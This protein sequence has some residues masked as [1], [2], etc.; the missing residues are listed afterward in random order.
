MRSL[1][2]SS[3]VVLIAAL[4][5]A[6]A[7]PPPCANCLNAKVWP[8]DPND[9]TQIGDPQFPETARLASM[10]DRVDLGIAF[11]G[12][13][14]R[15]ATATLGQLRGLKHIGWLKR[16]RY[17]AAV[18]GGSWAALPYTYWK[19]ADDDLLGLYQEPGDLDHDKVLNTP[20]GTL[21]KIITE[22]AIAG[23][24]LREAV[25]EFRAFALSEEANSFID[26]FLSAL[27]KGRREAGR[28]NKTYSRLLEDNFIKPLF[29]SQSALRVGWEERSVDQI[30]ADNPGALSSHEFLKVPD[31]RPFFIAGATLVP[32]HPAFYYP[33]LAPVEYTPLYSGIRQQF[34]AIGGAYVAT[35][36]Y[37]SV[38]VSQGDGGLVRVRPAADGRTFTV[39]DIISSTGAAP[40]L[41]LLLGA[42][43]TG[44]VNN[45]FGT[46]SG[47]FPSYH[48]IAVRDTGPALAPETPHGDGGFMDYF[49]IMPLLARHVRNIIVFVNSNNDFDEND[50]LDSLFHELPKNNSGD[51]SM[52]VVFAPAR[53]T[54]LMTA[55]SQRRTAGAPPVYC[56]PGWDVAENQTYNIRRYGDLN[57]CW[58]YNRPNA[59]WAKELKAPIAQ[60]MSGDKTTQTK[61]EKDAGSF[62]DF[63]W[64]KTFLQ[65]PPYVI[66]LSTAQV[67]LLSNLTA[68]TVANKDSVDAMTT[69]IGRVVNSRPPAALAEKHN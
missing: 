36:A 28:I 53:Y 40:Q 49:G 37:D 32:A 64:Y 19:G 3:L 52:N 61:A 65:K 35:W 29:G 26:T 46:A 42:R 21:S 69:V 27:D 38:D 30:A 63:P 54:E 16:V 4:T 48:P 25:G 7:T 6:G 20:N 13:G 10:P 55:L 59:A 1:L 9:F 60:I 24:G 50:D 68:W 12:G 43:G 45:V 2:L 67:N 15:S 47:Y 14:T 31:D 22:S 17:I 44:L 34:G 39:A 41:T 8:I 33:P 58:V 51:K 66:R 18:S 62:S 5:V 23:P 57:I 11:S 56:S